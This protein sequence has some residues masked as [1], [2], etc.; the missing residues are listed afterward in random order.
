MKSD[1]RPDTGYGIPAK[2]LRDLIGAAI[3]PAYT[4][5]IITVASA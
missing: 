4:P 1:L 2:N 5:I 3:N